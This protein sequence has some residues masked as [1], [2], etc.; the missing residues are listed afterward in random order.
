M[1]YKLYRD[2]IATDGF[3]C[4]Y[5]VNERWVFFFKFC[6]KRWFI[7]NS[8]TVASKTFASIE[9]FLYCTPLIMNFFVNKIWNNVTT[10]L[11][12][13]Q[14]LVSVQLLYIT[15]T[16][17][18]NLLDMKSLKWYR[19]Y[20]WISLSTKCGTTLRLDCGIASL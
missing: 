12:N 20:N 7:L 16:L 14:S 5:I 2:H 19:K 3:M 11:L 18:K 17:V 10:R 1:I 4:R 6:S 9:Y 15:V 13:S 8:E